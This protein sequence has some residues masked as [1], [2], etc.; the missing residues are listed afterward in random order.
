MALSRTISTRLPASVAKEVDAVARVE[1]R[2]ASHVVARLVTEGLRMRRFPGVIFVDGP[3]GRR[4]HV[5]G[6]GF[7]VWELMTLLRSYGGE[8]E[9]VLGDHPRIERRHLELARGYAEAF[10]EE[11]ESVI[12]ENEAAGER[13]AKAASP[14]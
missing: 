1:G 8:I 3:A 7:D 14:R 2:T 4:A 13:D 5:A 6:T 12:R 9:A 10:R 11:I